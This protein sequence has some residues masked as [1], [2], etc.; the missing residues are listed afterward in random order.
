MGDADASGWN[1]IL[2]NAGTGMG[3]IFSSPNEM[4]AIGRAIL[5]SSLLPPN[6][7]RAWLKPTSHTSSLIGAVGRAWEIYRTIIGAP[8]NNRVVDLY[9]KSGN[10][11]GFGAKLVLIP[12][13]DVG[14]VVMMAGRRGITADQISG[15]IVDHLLPALEDAA[16]REAEHKFS[17]T[18]IAEHGPNSTVTFST[19]AEMP[20]LG[21]DRWISNGTDMVQ[22]VFKSPRSFRMYPTNIEEEQGKQISWRSSYIFIDDT[23]TFSACPSWIALGR[24]QYGI[25]GLDEFVFE[26]DHNDEVIAVEPKA[27][28][29]RLVKVA[30]EVR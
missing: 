15:V 5:A 19:T 3:A 18:F 25:Y 23:G 13:Y 9:T 4:S 10:V 14:F 27:L 21:I 29:I 11:A 28:K 20:G 2:D 7:T 8:E 16:R 26:L 12:D 1:L 17:G 30:M 6:T 22:E 24:P